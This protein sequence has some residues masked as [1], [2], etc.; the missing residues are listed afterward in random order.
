MAH[1][2]SVRLTPDSQEF[3]LPAARTSFAYQP[4]FPPGGG[5]VVAAATTIKSSAAYIWFTSFPFLGSGGSSD[6]GFGASGHFH[7]PR[8]AYQPA[9]PSGGGMIEAATTTN[10]T[11]RALMKH[12]I[13]FGFAVWLGPSEP[14]TAGRKS[15]RRAICNSADNKDRSRLSDSEIATMRIATTREDSSSR[16]DN[17]HLH[18]VS[19]AGVG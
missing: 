3:A 11:R 17:Y 19:I 14:F 13:F 15:S 12:L 9:L 16:T 1:R 4:A 2:S 18:I 7:V 6:S 5:S 8:P 10:S